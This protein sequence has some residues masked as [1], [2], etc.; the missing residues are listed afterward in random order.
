LIVSAAARWTLNALSGGYA[1]T[2]TREGALADEPV[3]NAYRVL[4]EGIESFAGAGARAAESDDVRYATDARGRRY[5]TTL[6]GTSD[7]V[8]QKSEWYN[9]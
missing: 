1:Y 8:P 5:L 9:G 6:G 4:I 3:L 2:R 7:A